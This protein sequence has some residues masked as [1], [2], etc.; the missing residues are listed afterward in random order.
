MCYV[1]Y[2]GGMTIGPVM[3]RLLSDE[4]FVQL[5][6][7]IVQGE[8][9]PGENVRDVDLANR[10][11]L[12]RTPVREALTRLVA[13]GLVETKPS[14]YTR[15]APLRR[16]DA[17]RT[18]A[19]LRALDALAIR[20]AVPK[21]TSTDIEAM[22]TANAE[23]SKADGVT[24]ALA[25][26]DRFH[27]I[28]LLVADNPTLTQMV[29]QLHPLIHRI[30]Y[31]KFSTLMGGENTV[32]HHDELIA[33]CASGDGEAAAALSGEHWEQLGGHIDELFDNQ[34]LT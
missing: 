15:V 32:Q 12:S 20:T 3:R 30:L 26:D 24:A 7:A 16:I 2:T 27:A 8:L 25:A 17:Q 31:R 6:D 23:F 13:T 5:R 19:V 29:E 18:L 4:V 14:V 33:L 28:P 11:G 21:M 22:R 9:A 34:E 10:F 1:Q